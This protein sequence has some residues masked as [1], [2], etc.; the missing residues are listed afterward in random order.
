[1]RG[2]D[3]IGQVPQRRGGI[4]RLALRHIEPGAAKFALRQRANQGFLVDETAPPDIDEPAVPQKLELL[5]PDDPRTAGYRKQ[6]T[7]RLY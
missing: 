1:M 6:L 5:G 4:E 2:Q 3:H 7:A